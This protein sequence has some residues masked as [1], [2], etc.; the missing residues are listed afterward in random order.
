MLIKAAHANRLSD[1]M[2]AAN[3]SAVG[4]VHAIEA[5]FSGKQPQALKKYLASI[6]RAIKRLTISGRS[7]HKADA[8]ALFEGFGGMANVVKGQDGRHKN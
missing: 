8:Q 7:D 3:T 2:S 4:A 6:T 5:G 1:L